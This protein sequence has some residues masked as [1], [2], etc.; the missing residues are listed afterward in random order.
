MQLTATWIVESC[1]TNDISAFHISPRSSFASPR[2]I[3]EATK[4]GPF[5]A[6]E[7]AMNAP[8]GDQLCVSA[9]SAGRSSLGSP[10]P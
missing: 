1:P 4:T 8:S 9:G 10:F 6:F 5:I 3:T 7:A 2:S